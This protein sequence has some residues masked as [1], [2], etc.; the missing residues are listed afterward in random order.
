M[1]GIN[2]LNVKFID[3]EDDNHL[4]EIQQRHPK[5]FADLCTELLNSNEHLLGEGNAAKVF[6]IGTNPSYCVKVIKRQMA[7]EAVQLPI[8]MEAQIQ[9]RA[10]GLSRKN[11]FIPKPKM[12]IPKSEDNQVELLVM[13]R[14]FGP[15]LREVLDGTAPLPETFDFQKFFE[16]LSEYVN[17]LHK[18]DIH[19]RDLHE[20]NVMIDA[21]T[22][23]PK[24]I[25]FG[26]ALE[27]IGMED[28]EIYHLT[29]HFGGVRRVVSD[30]SSVKNLKKMMINFMH[31]LHGELP[32]KP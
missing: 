1:E 15:T 12:Y 16:K 22:G 2:S 3:P 23:E 13:E 31:N 24:I 21:K 11:S 30:N 8:E 25:D 26:A 4:F 10:W 19:H 7:E 6:Y 17:T 5:M 18:D 32:Q 9:R 20:G 14:I 27:S 28:H 29:G